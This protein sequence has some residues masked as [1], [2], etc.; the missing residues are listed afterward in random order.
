MVMSQ[1]QTAD[2]AP[3][4]ELVAS[5]RLDRYGITPAD[6]ADQTWEDIVALV[7]LVTL[8][9]AWDATYGGQ[10]IPEVPRD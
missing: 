1:P 4:G 7:S 10:V 2:P 5:L 3:Y 9:D 8:A 6:L